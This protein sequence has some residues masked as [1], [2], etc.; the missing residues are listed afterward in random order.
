MLLLTSSPVPASPC[1][2][3]RWNP[4]ASPFK[5]EGAA[6]SPGMHLWSLGLPALCSTCRLPLNAGQYPQSAGQAI[7]PRGPFQ[8]A[9]LGSNK[10][11]RRLGLHVPHATHVAFR[12]L[13][14]APPS[15]SHF[16]PHFAVPAAGPVSQVLR[17][18][19]RELRSQD[20]KQ[21]FKA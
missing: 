14:V 6:V 21:Q 16:Q 13:P 1:L 9:L 12:K 15:R 19:F 5:H 2:P 20:L 10:Q 7:N 18:T 8:L 4:G 17:V 3:C 11:A